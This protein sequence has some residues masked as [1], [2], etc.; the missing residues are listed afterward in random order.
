MTRVVRLYKVG[1]QD[2]A[3]QRF[4][5]AESEARAQANVWSRLDGKVWIE[6]L[7]SRKHYIDPEGAA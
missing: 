5:E 3:D 7:G 4:F 2:F 6:R 1:N